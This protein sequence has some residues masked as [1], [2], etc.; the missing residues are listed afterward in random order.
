MFLEKIGLLTEEGTIKRI[1]GQK[2]WVTTV[3]SEACHHCEA[4]GACKVLGSGKEVE[5]MADNLAGG[6][7]GDRVLLG[8]ERKSVLLATFLVYMVPVLF[9]MIGAVIGS[10]ISSAISMNKDSA[11]LICSLIFF[12]VTLLIVRRK[13]KILGNKQEYTPKIIK[14]LQGGNNG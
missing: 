1:D 6:R 7:E 14:V 3:R 4:R 10:K 5:V 11:A 12:T 2:A 13:G 8:M 9:M